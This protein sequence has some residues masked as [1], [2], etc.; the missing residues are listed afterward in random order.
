MIKSD[1]KFQQF[2]LKLVLFIPF[3]LFFY[4]IYI[5]FSKDYQGFVNFVVELADKKDQKLII[6]QKF[7]SQSVFFTGRG[8]LIILF[9]CYAVF[10]YVFVRNVD[11]VL[12]NFRT[13]Y[14]QLQ[15]IFKRYFVYSKREGQVFWFFI[16]L[17]TIKTIF[18][19]EF[20]ELQYDEAWTYLHFSSKGLIISAFSPNN[21][22]IFYTLFAA[23]LDIF[24]LPAKWIIR[25]PALFSVL[26]TL[27]ITFSYL[28]YHF[29]YRT[30]IFTTIFL[31]SS[32]SFHF[33][34][35]LGRGY[36]FLLLFTMISLITVLGITTRSKNIKIHSIV[37]ILA[38]ILGLYSNPAFFYVLTGSFIFLIFCHIND[39]LFLKK[40]L[41]SGLLI[42]SGS[43]FLY[44]PTI[45]T[46]SASILSIAANDSKEAALPTFQY[47]NRLTDWL[48]F[49]KD[50]PVFFLMISCVL[51]LIFV[52]KAFKNNVL[53]TKLL[54]F[55]ALMLCLPFLS[56]LLTSMQVPYRIWCYESVFISI[57]LVVGLH[58]LVRNNFI[59][60][61]VVLGMSFLNIFFSFQHYFM[62]WSAE[63]DRESKKISEI[64]LSNEILP[65]N[66]YFFS[67]YDKPLVEYY[68]LI[69]HKP[70]KSYMPFEESK[71]YQSFEKDIYDAVLLDFEDYQPTERDLERI[72]ENPYE[73]K[74]ENT[75]IKLYLLKK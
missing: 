53:Q 34:S 32:N 3:L 40:L 28:K 7:L 50:W 45:L 63:L 29:G 41:I 17:F 24:P 19:F 54:Y 71:N 2:F 70:L 67:R 31:A 65:E 33:F 36:G 69:N 61:T 8:L 59:F 37:F 26:A 58:L 6:Q 60:M 72:K 48:F 1:F 73:L 44:L 23:F 66:C 18:F 49:G 9:L 55:C 43:F 22:H 52:A 51:Y 16:T 39:F 14:F 25:L 21:N 5:F 68:F 42:A 74:Y 30:A 62:N 4:L 75:R 35:I 56:F 13:F 11:S 27:I 64:M 12:N 57:G 15:A 10:F 20:Y 46:G 47:L 38:S